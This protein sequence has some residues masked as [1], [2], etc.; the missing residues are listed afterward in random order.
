[1]RQ[2]SATSGHW[3]I[4]GYVISLKSTQTAAGRVIHA[5]ANPEVI[6]P[7]NSL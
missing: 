6:Q 5:A 4:E 2:A 7:A 1:M 3:T